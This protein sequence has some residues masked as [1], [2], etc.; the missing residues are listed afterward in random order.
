MIAADVSINN[1]YKAIH[2]LGKQSCIAVKKPY[3]SPQ[4][5]QHRLDFARAHLHWTIADWSQVI[6]TDKSLFELGKPVTQRHIW[7]SINQ[8]YDL[9][10]MAVNHCSGRHSIMVWGALCGPIQSELILIPP[11]QC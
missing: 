3:L 11:G 8:K 2:E 5:M 6:W 1:L 9:E 7:R 10:L 4:H